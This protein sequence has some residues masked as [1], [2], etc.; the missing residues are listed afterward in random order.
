M[1]H[2]EIRQEIEFEG[3]T[4]DFVSQAQAFN[5][6]NA[7]AERLPLFIRQAD[8]QSTEI[9]MYAEEAEGYGYITARSLPESRTMLQAS[10][11]SEKDWNA[12]E[13][14]W[15]SFVDCL[16]RDGWVQGKR[17]H[18]G[19][20]KRRKDVRKL[21]AQGLVDKQIAGRLGWDVRTIARDRKAMGLKAR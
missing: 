19:I 5:Q 9:W 18:E 20:A 12:L 10:S 4:A 7:T 6:A 2:T 16:K 17:V 3:T 8:A 14:V 1:L 11:Y 21:F 15:D 13:E